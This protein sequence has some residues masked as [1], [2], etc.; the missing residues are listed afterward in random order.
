MQLNVD[1]PLAIANPGRAD[2]PDWRPIPELE[3]RQSQEAMAVAT[4]CNRQSVDGLSYLTVG[5]QAA[6]SLAVIA[7]TLAL[8]SSSKRKLAS[9]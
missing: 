8:E 7:G 2:L 1:A 5:V 4:N 9:S 3:N 6:E